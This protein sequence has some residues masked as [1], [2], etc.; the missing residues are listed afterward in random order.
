M[1]EKSYRKYRNSYKKK[2]S[3][4]LK[5]YCETRLINL[6]KTPKRESE[7][8]FKNFLKNYFQATIKQ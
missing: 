4:I 8:G 5:N 7:L 1:I 6:I 3:Y 2:V